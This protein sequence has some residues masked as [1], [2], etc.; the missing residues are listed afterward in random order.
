[1]YHHSFEEVSKTNQSP[2]KDELLLLLLPRRPEASI[3][4]SVCGELLLLPLPSKDL[5]MGDV[6]IMEDDDDDDVDASSCGWICSCGKAGGELTLWHAR[7][8]SRRSLSRPVANI[9]RGLV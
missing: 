3:G 5:W 2:K 9:L 6:E 1:M 8:I 4:V 7:S